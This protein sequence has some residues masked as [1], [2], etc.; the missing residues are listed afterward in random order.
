MYFNKLLQGKHPVT[1]QKTPGQS[2]QKQFLCQSQTQILPLSTKN[3]HHPD[4]YVHCYLLL[5]AVLS[6]YESLNIAVMC[7][8]FFLF[9]V[10]YVF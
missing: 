1:T 2:L 9:F 8:F 4:F 10:K 6:N 5:F 3:N 7:L